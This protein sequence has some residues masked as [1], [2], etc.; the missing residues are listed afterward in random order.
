MNEGFTQMESKGGKNSKNG[1]GETDGDGMRIQRPI[2]LRY[3]DDL[4]CFD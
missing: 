1:G 3:L 2:C 4:I